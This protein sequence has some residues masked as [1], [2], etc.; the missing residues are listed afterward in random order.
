MVRLEEAEG[1]WEAERPAHQGP[2]PDP[3]SSTRRRAP[4]RA[5]WLPGLQ[6]VASP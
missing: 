4:D 1:L 5:G 3:T 6:G 2:M